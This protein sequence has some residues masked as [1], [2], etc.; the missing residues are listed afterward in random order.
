MGKVCTFF[1]HRELYQD[2]GPQLEQAII[3]AIHQGYNI[4]WCG[5]YGAFD[6]CAAGTVHRLKKSYPHIQVVLILAYLPEHPILEIYDHSIFPEGIEIGPPRFAISR[7]N[8]WI[9]K[10]CDGAIC[11]VNQTYGGAYTAYQKLHRQDKVLTNLG[12]LSLKPYR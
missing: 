6:L 1:G 10:N 12:K 2:I 8:Q 11:Y 9:I 4:F 3:T 7:R 5:G